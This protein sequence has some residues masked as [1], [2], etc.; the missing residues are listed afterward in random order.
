VGL[1]I[2]ILVYSMKKFWKQY[3]TAN[4]A[5]VKYRTLRLCYNFMIF[6]AIHHVGTTYCY[7][8]LKAEGGIQ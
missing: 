6:K 8:A 5:A 2:E 4:L 7:W 3:F 1:T